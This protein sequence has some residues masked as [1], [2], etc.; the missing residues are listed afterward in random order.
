MHLVPLIQPRSQGPS[1]SSLGTRKG[2]VRLILRRVLKPEPSTKLKQTLE[3]VD[4]WVWSIPYS[5]PRSRG[6]S[7]S[8]N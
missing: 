4:K 3:S 7:P 2:L 8:V 6:N 1:S 5:K